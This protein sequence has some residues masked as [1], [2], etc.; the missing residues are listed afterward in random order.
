[1][2]K[3]KST[4]LIWSFS[5]LST[6]CIAQTALQTLQKADSLSELKNYGTA[7][8][9]YERLLFFADSNLLNVVY[10]NTALC[11]MALNKFGEAADLYKLASQASFSDSVYFKLL[12][13]QCICLIMDQQF[14]EAQKI[15]NEINL[16]EE[17]DYFRKKALFLNGI[18]EANWLNFEKASTSFDSCQGF[19]K[20]DD[21]DALKHLLQQNQKSTN[22][23]V[24]AAGIYSAILPGLGQTFHGDFK[25]GINSFVLNAVFLAAFIY[26]GNQYNYF[27]SLLFYS[28]FFPRYYL[29]GITSSKTIATQKLAAEKT[30]FMNAYLNIYLKY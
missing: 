22:I 1:M 30:R 11:K 9:L 19:I 14:R 12:L 27:S 3:L 17:P 5:F 7:E 20:P 16:V 4:L 28:F 6:F 23:H 21:F 10:E 15:I 24:N 29:G 26:T 25:N 13:Q 8:I 18:L 2:M